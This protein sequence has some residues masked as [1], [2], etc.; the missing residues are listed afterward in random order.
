MLFDSN[1]CPGS[2]MFLF[3]GYMGK[4]LHTGDM[5]WNNWMMDDMLYIFPQDKRISEENCSIIIDEL[6]Y[7]NTYCDPIFKFPQR[8]SN[9]LI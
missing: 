8:V 1:H 4:I 6:Y 7:D 3:E 5:R 9:L 2:V